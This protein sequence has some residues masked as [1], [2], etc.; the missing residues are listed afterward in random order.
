MMDAYDERHLFDA[1]DYHEAVIFNFDEN[2]IERYKT[3]ASKELPLHKFSL[4]ISNRD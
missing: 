1:G 2:K 4:S 3:A